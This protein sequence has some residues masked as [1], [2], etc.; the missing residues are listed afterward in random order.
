MSILRRIT[1][2][3]HIS[4]VLVKPMSSSTAINNHN[5]MHSSP[6]PRALKTNGAPGGFK[7]TT[8]VI[9]SGK[10]SSPYSPTQVTA[11]VYNGTHRK[12]PMD[13][14]PTISGRHRVGY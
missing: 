12:N 4:K 10:H 8:G 2:G 5:R 9:G 14:A 11:K 1:S 13:K 3:P 7:P 6:A